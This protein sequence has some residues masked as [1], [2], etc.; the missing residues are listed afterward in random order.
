M[1]RAPRVCDWSEGALHRLLLSLEPHG[2]GGLNRALNV[3]S[4]AP[5]LAAPVIANSNEG[6]ADELPVEDAVLAPRLHRR[7]PWK[8]GCW[9]L[10]EA[11]ADIATR[12]NQRKSGTGT[13]GIADRT[14]RKP[15]PLSP[16]P[17]KAPRERAA[18]GSPEGQALKRP[19]RRTR[20]EPL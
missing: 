16:R 17:G 19:P 5:A 10:V 15:T 6:N 7:G 18:T 8:F 1:G 12:A 11:C 4:D 14:T 20:P 13:Q 9:T 3:G 2:I